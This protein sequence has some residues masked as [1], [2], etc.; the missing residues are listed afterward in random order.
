MNDTY[1]SN[2]IFGDDNN[3]GQD[4]R[5]QNIQ[6]T[7]I[8]QQEWHK[9]QYQRHVKGDQNVDRLYQSAR[10][11]SNRPMTSTPTNREITSEEQ[12]QITISNRSHYQEIKTRC[13]QV[14]HG[15]KLALNHE[16]EQEVVDSNNLRREKSAK[17]NLNS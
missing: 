7:I 16:N 4:T 17:R 8:D 3:D 6:N 14:G 15:A 1:R 9:S 12:S 13:G 2:I 11:K 5:Y 10:N